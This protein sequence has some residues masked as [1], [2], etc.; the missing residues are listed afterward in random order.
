M[1]YYGFQDITGMRTTE[2]L[3]IVQYTFFLSKNT[4]DTLDAFLSKI[5]NRFNVVIGV[6]PEAIWPLKIHEEVKIESVFRRNLRSARP[7]CTWFLKD[8]PD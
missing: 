2:I 7:C 5:V 1:K 3:N 8:L 6:V 4:G